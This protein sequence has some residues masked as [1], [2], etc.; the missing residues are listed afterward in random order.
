[1]SETPLIPRRPPR[2]RPRWVDE[3]KAR[4]AFLI[5]PVPMKPPESPKA[6]KPESPRTGKGVTH[7]GAEL[8]ALALKASML[9]FQSGNR[10]LPSEVLDD[11]AGSVFWQVA[12]DKGQAADPVPRVA[13]RTP[14]RRVGSQRGRVDMDW[15]SR[16][17]LC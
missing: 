13:W 9:R 1:M 4:G 12:R 15:P 10:S 14:P 16:L 6:R 8:D 2:R 17:A 7:C 3:A 5:L 11:A